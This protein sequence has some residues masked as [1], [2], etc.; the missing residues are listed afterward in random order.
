[1][2]F[3][4][5]EALHVAGLCRVATMDSCCHTYFIPVAYL[6]GLKPPLKIHQTYL[7]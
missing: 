7:N 1:M 6:I 2:G 4:Y 3:R 5:Y